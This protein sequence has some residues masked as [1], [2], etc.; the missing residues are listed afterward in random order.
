MRVLVAEDEDNIRDGLIE[1]LE[2][3]GYAAIGARDGREALDLYERERPDFLCLDIMMPKLNGYD[4][5]REIRKRDA[6]VPIV[7]ISAKS[8][9]VDRVLGLELGADDFIMK[10]FGVREVIARIRAVTRRVYAHRAKEARPGSF[11]M[12]DLE[13]VPAEL[14]AR[15]EDAMIDL[16]LREVRIL[17]FFHQNPGRVLERNEIFD[18]CWGRQYF[19]N[20]RTLDQHI[21]QLRKRIERDHKTPEIIQTVH[22]AGYRYEP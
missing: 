9:E 19:P 17:E 4:V 2:R 7:F 6:A 18:A 15:R 12:R 13:I 22:G 16:S 1:V 8:E 5:C 21:V 14:R 20:S 3:E 11:Q 10:P